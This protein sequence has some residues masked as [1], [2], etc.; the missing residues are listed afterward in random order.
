MNIITPITVTDAMIG[1]A[2]T[3]AEP[4]AGETAWV[5]SGTYALGDRRIRTTTHRVYECV[6]AHTG[7]TALPEVDSAYWLEAGP[8]QRFAPFDVYTNTVATATTSLTF[9]VSPGFF[10]ALSLYGINGATLTVTVKDAPGGA[11][12]FSYI[13]SLYEA[14]GG[15]YEYLFLPPAQITKQLLT[16]IPIRPQA[17]ATITVSAAIGVAVG[18]GMIVAGDY[19][20]VAGQTDTPAGTEFGASAEPVTSSYIEQDD[21][22]TITIV[23][24][25]SATNMRGS[26]FMPRLAADA[27]L[28]RVQDVLDVPVAVIATDVAGY[29]GL[30]VFG[31][32][33]G[34]MV[35]PNPASA[36]LEYTVKGLF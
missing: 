19:A 29:S 33:S 20:A 7:R 32:L 31:L 28:K 5:S 3:I 24:R 17:E 11:N 10:N 36:S 26:V 35:Y 34:R 22:G 12:V 14:A 18:L 16:G 6:L 4:A 8:T 2:T 30:N 13:G 27:A 9:V 1:A 23:R 21:D 25:H 15:W